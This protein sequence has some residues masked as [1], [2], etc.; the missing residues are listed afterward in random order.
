[1]PG[2]SW[3]IIASDPETGQPSRVHYTH[4]SHL[5]TSQVIEFIREGTGFNPSEM[6][7]YAIGDT[8]LMKGFVPAEHWMEEHSADHVLYMWRLLPSAQREQVRQTSAHLGLA[9]DSLEANRDAEA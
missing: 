8:H 6:A 3:T 7:K 9:L 4:A 1:M 5:T 2:M